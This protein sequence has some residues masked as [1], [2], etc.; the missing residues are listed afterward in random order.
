MADLHP[1]FGYGSTQDPAKVKK[2]WKTGRGMRVN[3]SNKHIF[4]TSNY[5]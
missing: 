4:G 5:S 3:P 1:M 2:F